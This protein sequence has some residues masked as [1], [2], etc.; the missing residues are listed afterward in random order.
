M[1]VVI[2]VALGNSLTEMYIL[3]V[4]ELNRHRAKVLAGAQTVCVWTTGRYLQ[5]SKSELLIGSKM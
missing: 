2:P 3:T 5:V 1:D 4:A